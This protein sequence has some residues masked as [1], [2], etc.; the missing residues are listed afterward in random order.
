MNSQ[1]KTPKEIE[2][3][4][5][6]IWENIQASAKPISFLSWRAYHPPGKNLPRPFTLKKVGLWSNMG[7]GTYRPPW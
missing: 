7:A 1:P 6:K 5:E 3:F 4:V 2:E